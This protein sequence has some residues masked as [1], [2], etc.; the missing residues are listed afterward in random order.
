VYL[1]HAAAICLTKGGHMCRQLDA[2]VNVVV[3]VCVASISV[4]R[5]MRLGILELQLQLHL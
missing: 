2:P 1:A 4:C 3:V 5:F